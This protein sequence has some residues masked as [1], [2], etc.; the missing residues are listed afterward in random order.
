MADQ[1]ERFLQQAGWDHAARQPLAG[2][3]SARRYERLRRPDGSKAVLMIAPP[4][5]DD[6]TRRFAAIGAHLLDL[7]LSAPRILFGKPETGLLLLE[8]LGD[9]VFA[10]DIADD[11][12]REQPLYD[13]AIDLL[14]ALH[15]HPAPADLPR[16]DAPELAAMTAPSADW[17]AGLGTPQPDLAAALEA[18]LLPA[19][20]GLP[21]WDRPVL[22][23]RDFHA[24]NLIWLPE[25]AGVARVGLL[26]YQD[27]F[28]GLPA[29]DLVSLLEDARRD[30]A[31]EVRQATQDRFAKATDTAPRDLTLHLAV[32]G[33]QR[34]LRILGVFARLCLHFGKARYVDLIPRVW[35]HVQ[36]DLAHPALSAVQ[37]AAR[38]LPA[39]TPDFLNELR[40]KCGTCPTP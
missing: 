3:A 12:G 9:A 24:E 29:Y 33:A 34:N 38:A 31:P 30:L 8:D 11:P 25:R 2:D 22:A 7:G 15:R 21:G 6:S 28:A 17:Y 36:R 4:A 23:L 1:V 20:E 40:S 37:D 26:D 14:A 10:H 32:L 39:P 16:L 27:A 35:D 19:L 13:A 18:A 5:P